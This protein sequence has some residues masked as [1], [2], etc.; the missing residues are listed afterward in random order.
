MSDVFNVREVLEMAMQIERNGAAFYRKAAGMFEEENAKNTLL[1]LAAMEDMHEKT[2]MEMQDS[3]SS[4]TPETFDPEGEAASYLKALAAGHVFD[5]KTNPA[6][7]LTGSES[8]R[9]IIKKAI[10]LEKDSIVFYTGMKAFVPEGAG[11]QKMDEI[12]D[13]EVSHIT[14]LSNALKFSV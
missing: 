11:K 8:W 5:V 3:L 12:I 10:G 13:E 14:L 4:A 7:K 9:D 2:F 6:D 1:D